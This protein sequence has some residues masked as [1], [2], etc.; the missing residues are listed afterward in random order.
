M[1][2]AID[3]ITVE[4]IG[5]HLEFLTEEMGITLVKSSYSTNIKER[6]DCCAVLLDAEGQT[7]SLTAYTGG[8]LGSV[9]GL[10]DELFKRY[11]RESLKPGDVFMA[12]DAHTGGPTHLPDITVVAPYFHD[13][14]LVAFCATVG[15]HTEVGGGL[16]A[17]VDIWGEG[18]RI[19]PIKVFSGGELRED[20]LE[21]ILLNMR[22]PDERR[23]DLEAQF[24]GV[25]IG[26][27]RLDELFAHY[28]KEEILGSVQILFDQTERRIRR[29]IEALPDGRYEFEDVMDDDGF[30]AVNIPIRC[31]I[32]IKGD[33]IELDFTGTSKQVKGGINVTFSALRASVY[34]ALK[35]A[36]APDVPANAGLYRAIRI[37]AP[38]GSLVN[39]VEP[40]A[41]LNR[42]D[43]Y[44][45]VIDVI[46]GALAPA[47]PDKVI[48]ACKGAITGI[49]FHGWTGEDERYW[50][51]LETIA[52]GFG[53]RTGLDGVDG[54]QTGTA[55]TS[56]LPS[57]AM[58]M[59]YPLFVERYELIPDSG[60][61][62]TWRGGQ[63]ILRRYRVLADRT[64][65]RTKGDR[66]KTQ[67]WGLFEGEPGY[68]GRFILNPG[69]PGERELGSKEF[70]IP[71][72]KGDV[73]EVWTPGS[74]GYGPTR[75]RDRQAVLR[76]VLAG[77]I[78]REAALTH[79]GVEIDDE[80][81]DRLAR[82]L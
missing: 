7:I 61:A 28:S 46:I 56:N 62:G 10:M 40:A 19:P 78:S 37:V 76:D 13:G 2:T 55:N 9:L 45:R 41:V 52:G 57:E 1:S 50:S 34:Y 4:V 36:L 11:P 17:A 24:A 27:R 16:G 71:T 29:S 53:A 39:C 81:L 48:A 79:Y 25:R 63:G 74:G 38:R 58:E 22:K 72:N 23:G 33:G 15:H 47:A 6:R 31:A 42:S 20:V 64:F 77:Q 82:D 26:Q 21:L 32:T 75:D 80:E 18:V 67:P 43:C 12:N 14:E 73:V 30:D 59:E 70:N 66:C 44:S 8:H 49:G 51:Y 35:C 65:F 3:P 68:A 5:N 54:V 69:T 60:G